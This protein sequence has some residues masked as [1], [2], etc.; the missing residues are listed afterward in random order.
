MIR[1]PDT[2]TGYSTYKCRFKSSDVA[3]VSFA[4]TAQFMTSPL[5]PDDPRGRNLTKCKLRPR[6]RPSDKLPQFIC[7]FSFHFLPSSQRRPPKTITP[8]R[9]DVLT[10]GAASRANFPDGV[11][12]YWVIH[13]L[14]GLCR[15]TFHGMVPTSWSRGS[16][17]W[18]LHRKETSLWIPSLG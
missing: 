12:L 3:G 5:R 18:W 6:P 1:S 15:R 17:K 8:S 11:N 13:R 7:P 10:T 4:C 14:F 9:S 16:K 2:Y